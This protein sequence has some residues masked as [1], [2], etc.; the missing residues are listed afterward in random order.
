MPEG[1]V[2]PQQIWAPRKPSDA[3]RYV[4]HEQ[5]HPPIFFVHKDGE[6]LGL[7]LT[8]A[9][10]G[11]CMHLRGAE[12]AAR[13]GTTTH[14]Q[15]RINWCGYLYLEWSDQIMIQKQSPAKETIS[16]EKFAKYVA[17]KVLK[18]MEHAR[19]TAYDNDRDQR[20]I[21]GDY[22]ITPRNVVLIGV[23]QVSQGSWMPIL[24]L[25]SGFGLCLGL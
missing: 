8:D 18:F 6:G 25:N 3:Q 14:A 7:P 10:A 12:Q 21:I 2:I 11:N 24:Q 5:L 20:W 9:A 22:H 4:Y 23:V 13:V 19:N 1:P 17:G 15:I 16:L